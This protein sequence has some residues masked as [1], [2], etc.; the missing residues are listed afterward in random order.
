MLRSLRAFLILVA[1]GQLILAAAFFF[2]WPLVTDYWPIDGTTPLTFILFAAFFAAVAAS[3]LWPILSGNPG[4]LAGVGLDY[5]V[6]LGPMAV[7]TLWLGTRGEPGFLLFGAICAA[8]VLFG[9]GL[10]RQTRR[11]PLDTSIP[12]PAPVRVSFAVFVV[13][14]VYT[15]I[16]LF[17]QMPTIPWPVTPELSVIIGCLF[18]GAATYFVYGLLRPSWSNAAGQLAGFLAYDLVL[19]GP[20]IRL[21]ATVAPEFQARLLVYTIVVVYSGLLAIYY[22][23]I[24]RQTRLFGATAPAAGVSNA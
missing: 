24:N 6:I 10:F 11:L 21:G 8:G 5:M 1:A 20:I 14:L 2:R 7:Y 19:I 15:S 9:L 22:L 18:L 12:M 16:R 3:T 4:A 23:F 17:L 13:A